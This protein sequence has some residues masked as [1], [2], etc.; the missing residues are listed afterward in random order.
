MFVYLS[1]KVLSGVVWWII[2]HI[3]KID[4]HVIHLHT[5]L[6]THPLDTCHAE[7]TQPWWCRSYCRLRPTPFIPRRSPF[8]MGQCFGAFIGTM[9]KDIWLA[10][11]T[12]DC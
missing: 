12:M 5:Y 6:S 11:E 8:R 10:V 1:K 3:H 9:T 7:H 4:T 2:T